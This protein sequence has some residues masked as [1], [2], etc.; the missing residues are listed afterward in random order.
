MAAASCKWT[1]MLKR[2]SPPAEELPA[3]S[4]EELISLLPRESS[5]VVEVGLEEVEHEEAG[6]VGS[7]WALEVV[8]SY[9]TSAARIGESW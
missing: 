5:V 2:G 6:P 8:R 7:C 1:S 9:P 3:I 4:T